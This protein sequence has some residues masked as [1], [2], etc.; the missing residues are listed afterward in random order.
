MLLRKKRWVLTSNASLRR[1]CA[2]LSSA[3][4][5]FEGCVQF[6]RKKYLSCSDVTASFLR[7]FERLLSSGVRTGPNF[8][9]FGLYSPALSTFKSCIRPIQGFSFVRAS[10]ELNNF[11]GFLS[12]DT[13]FVMS[14]ELSPCGFMKPWLPTK[15]RFWSCYVKKARTL[16][17]HGR[18]EGHIQ[19]RVK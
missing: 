10:A 16:G 3:W 18:L 12:L 11:V 1:Y 14:I 19:G 15:N 9:S 2:L 7:R 4:C 5:G 13:F 17:S 8:F 6:Y